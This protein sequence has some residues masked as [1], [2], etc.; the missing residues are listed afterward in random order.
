MQEAG[1]RLKTDDARGAAALFDRAAA[2]AHDPITIDG[3]R[4]RAA[5]LLMDTAP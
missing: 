2:A 1:I 4:L 5:F 3:A